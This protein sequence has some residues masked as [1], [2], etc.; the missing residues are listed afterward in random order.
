MPSNLKRVPGLFVEPLSKVFVR[1][2]FNPTEMK[3][4]K[5]VRYDYD[6][7]PLYYTQLPIF[8]GG[9][10]KTLEFE[11]FFDRT[12]ASPQSGIYRKAGIG[13]MDIQAAIETFLRPAEP[14]LLANLESLKNTVRGQVQ[15]AERVAAPPDCLFL[16]GTRWYKT[17]MT[18]A[19][20]T[21]S[22]Y[23]WKLLP[24]RFTVTGLQLLVIEF[25]YLFRLM[26]SERKVLSLAGSAVSLAEA[27]A[28]YLR[29]LGE[30]GL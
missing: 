6:D 21:E 4:N 17:K 18:Q 19:P 3:I 20:M 13:V 12:E 14:P 29:A 30:L 27:S 16:Y 28:D 10:H 2:Q 25:G 1:F 24:L 11:L 7:I 22:F 15:D 5:Q 26:E 8:K 23:D 9:G